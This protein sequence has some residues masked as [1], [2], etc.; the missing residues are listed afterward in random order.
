MQMHAETIAHT[1][2]VYALAVLQCSMLPVGTPGL[3]GSLQ[4]LGTHQFAQAV[5]SHAVLFGLSVAL[6][7]LHH[8]AAGEE[9]C[10]QNE[11]PVYLVQ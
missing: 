3:E 9:P 7:E 11:C 8:S 1:N 4:R 2:L 6:N 5:A 10:P